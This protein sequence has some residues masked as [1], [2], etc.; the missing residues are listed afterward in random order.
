MESLG[1]PLSIL[2]SVVWE[3]HRL[4]FPYPTPSRAISPS[5]VG[6]SSDDDDDDDDD[7][8]LVMWGH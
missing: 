6:T 3:G 1:S 5:D 2:G 4:S 8:P 7:D